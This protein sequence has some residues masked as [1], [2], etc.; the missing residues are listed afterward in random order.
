M[1]EKPVFTQVGFA[2][3]VRKRG[4]FGDQQ[5]GAPRDVERPQGGDKGGNAQIG[6]Q[7]AV[8]RANQKASRECRDHHQPGMEVDDDAERVQHQAAVDQAAGKDSSQASDRSDREVDPPAEDDEGHPDRQN[9]IDGDVL[10][11]DRK[12]GRGQER[13]R[14]DR[15]GRTQGYQHDQRPQPEQLPAEGA[16]P[17]L[18]GWPAGCRLRLNLWTH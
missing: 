14:Q 2:G 18:S 10:Y 5:R 1:V 4:A 17:M 12:V 8:D 15:E 9:R 11:Q 16:R 13:R 3:Q 6:D 7:H